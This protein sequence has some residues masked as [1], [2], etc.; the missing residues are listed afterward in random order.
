M[1]RMNSLPGSSAATPAQAQ[2]AAAPAAAPTAAPAA[3]TAS[4]ISIDVH[5]VKTEDWTG[6][7]EVYVRIVG[8][9][10][11]ATSDI[12][13]LNDGQKFT[14]SLPAKPFGDFS[15][16]VKVEVYDE[17]WPDADDLIVRMT[18]NPPYGA[19]FTYSV[20]RA[21][22]EGVKIVLNITE[23]SGRQVRRLPLPSEVGV[24]RIAWDL[25]GEA[26]QPGASPRRPFPRRSRARG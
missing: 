10:G 7:D 23:E 3:V 12:H 16:P 18:W 26:P 6:A 11:V 5:V 25:R 1:R 21:A 22:A 20:G 14:F 19:I 9:G 17:D 24:N 15:K 8:P 4:R 2:P 13:K